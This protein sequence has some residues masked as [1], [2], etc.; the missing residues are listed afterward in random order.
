MNR[1]RRLVVTSGILLLGLHVRSEV[2]HACP[3]PP[4][5]YRPVSV[6]ERVRLSAVVI[7]GTVISTTAPTGNV[8]HVAV[9]ETI[10]GESPGMMD[11]GGFGFGHD[12]ISTVHAGQ[13]WIFFTDENDG[14]FTA[15]HFVRFD[16]VAEVNKVNLAK[17]H[18]AARGVNLVLLPVLV[19]R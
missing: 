6:E 4:P 3:P 10:K 19:R 5:D 12:C 14:G 18:G 11:I 2:A 1:L 9:E 16:S 15:R 17:A 13:R 8:A 7:V